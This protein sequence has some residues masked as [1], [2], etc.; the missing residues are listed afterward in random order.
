M[1]QLADP[2]GR[3]SAR[4][5]EGPHSRGRAGAVLSDGENVLERGAG[6]ERSPGSLRVRLSKEVKPQVRRDLNSLTIRAAEHDPP[7][8]EFA[9]ELHFDPESGP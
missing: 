1:Q 8:V 6:S 4:L 3:E 7:A 2:G 9:A 5:R